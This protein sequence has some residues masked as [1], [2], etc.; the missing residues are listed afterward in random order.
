MITL[1]APT[2]EAREST[3]AAVAEETG[4]VFVHPSEDPSM[5]DSGLFRSSYFVNLT[6]PTQE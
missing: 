6:F 1:C 2:Q 5:W 3:A 4:A